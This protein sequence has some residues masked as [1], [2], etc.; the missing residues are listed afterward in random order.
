MVRSMCLAG[1]RLQC[2]LAKQ[3]LKFFLTLLLGSFSGLAHAQTPATPAPDPG[4]SARTQILSRPSGAVVSLQGEYGL[5][6]RAPYTVVHYLKGPYKIRATK[7]G[8]ENWSKE[9]FF[10]GK[11]NEKIS[12][13][14]SPKTRLKGFYRSMLFPGWGQAYADQRLKGGIIASAQCI[15]LGALLYQSAQYNEALDD[16]NSAAAAYQQGRSD[17]VQEPVLRGQLNAAQSELD[18]RYEARRRWALFAASIYVYNLLDI[19]L[20]FPSYHHNNV[21]VNLTVTPPVD[22]TTES[23]KVGVQAQF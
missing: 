19:I 2:L 22:P 20:F 21:D 13:K 16:F 23:F 4:L 6:G 12:I 11:G 18:D 14:L 8:Y 5:A 3:A 10:S 17:Q 7:Y 1:Q 15:S 9:F